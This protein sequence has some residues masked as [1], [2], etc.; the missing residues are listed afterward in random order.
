MLILETFL[1][2]RKSDDDIGISSQG[3]TMKIWTLL[4]KEKQVEDTESLQKGRTS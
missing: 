1:A 2:R 3:G 4:I